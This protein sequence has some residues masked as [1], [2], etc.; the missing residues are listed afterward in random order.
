MRKLFILLLVLQTLCLSAQNETLREQMRHSIPAKSVSDIP[1]SN[2][3]FWVG[4]GSR[5]VVFSL[6]A[7]GPSSPGGVAYGFRFDGNAT[8]LDLFEAIQT[9]DPH[10]TIQHNGG[11]VE[12]VSYADE[13][14]SYS[15][16]AGMLMYTV[17]GS[18]ASGLGDMLSNGDYLEL[19]EYSM[20]DDCL[21]PNN[22]IYYPISP[23]TELPEDAFINVDDIVYWV[24]NGSHHAMVAVNWCD[25]A[26]AM[27][28]GV[29]FDGDSAL[30]AD[31]MRT[32]QLYDDR[33]NY[34]NNNGV[35]ENI[36]FQDGNYNLSLQGNWWMYNINGVGAMQG[37][38][39]QYV[40]HG[41]FIKWGDEQ[42]GVS[43]ESY[44]YV[45]T[46][47]VQPVALPA[48][49]IESFDGIVGSEGCQAIRFDNPAILGWAD[50]CEVIR[51]LQDIA[52]PTGPV[53]SYGEESAGIGAASESTTDAI[54]LGD[55]GIA[56]LTFEQPISNGDGYDF[57][58]FENSLNDSFLELA[59]VEVSSD[60]NHFYRFP[61]VSNTST[62]VQISNGG[63]TAA[64]ALHN[65]AGKYRAGWGTTFDL[66]ELEGYS[67]L[68]INNITHV[69]LV[70]VVGAVDPQYGTVDKNG[71]L[72]NDPYPTA[73]AS[74]GFDLSGVA[75]LNGWVPSAIQQY[76]E[77]GN[78]DVYPNPCTSI[79]TVANI[80]AGE[81]V[82]FYDAFGQ[83]I[84]SE[85]AQDENVRVNMQNYP[86]GLYFVCT[87]N[88][89]CKIIKR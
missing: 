5:E 4:Q 41:D 8:I 86:S 60:G 73:F 39:D 75:V 69:R 72:I 16:E 24:G 42:C 51:G 38:N 1:A 83:L 89:R 32:I 14:I 20:D 64:T 48:L 76:A 62:D 31:L 17:N 21:L 74:C 79:V 45:W 44:N 25:T 66:A 59:F 13:S 3:K 71:H 10:F 12:S 35:V 55:G 27:A 67:N 34:T 30:V 23:E 81:I 58:V 19:V 68:D 7:C 33:F 88:Q 82:S 22:N 56:V 6:F 53:A 26:V 9:A 84:W 36:T 15:I 57:A 46:T 50:H 40:H 85:V 78:L 37:L 49:S 77:K 43:D 54:S 87:S 61:A 28:W 52:A 29:R 11:F 70:D 2:I 65:L 18:Y 63:A 47:S 80:K